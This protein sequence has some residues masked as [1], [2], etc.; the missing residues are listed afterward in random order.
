MAPKRK[1]AGLRRKPPERCEFRIFLAVGIRRLP[2][3]TS[4]KQILFAA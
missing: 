3:Q 1:V 4:T 2:A